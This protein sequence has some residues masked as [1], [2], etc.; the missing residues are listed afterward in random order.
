MIPGVNII[1][2][3]VSVARVNGAGRSLG[4]VLGGPRPLRKFLSSKEHVDSLKIDLNVAK[5]IT[6]QDYKAQKIS[7]D[8]STYIQ[9]LN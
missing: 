1:G 3:I 4:E 2:R 7:V 9:C 6:V 8:G 5:I